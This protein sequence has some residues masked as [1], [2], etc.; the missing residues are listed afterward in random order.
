Q[1]RIA[2]G[3]LVV[4]AGIS[5]RFAGTFENQ[6]RAE[7]RLMVLIP[8]VLTLI[9]LVLYLQFRRSSTA[10]I[11]FTGIAVAWTG[12]FL[13]IGLYAQPWFADFSVAGVNM[14]DLSQVGPV[15]L[16]I[17][18]WVGFIALFGIAVDDGVVMATY[19]DQR[20]KGAT[21]ANRDDPRAAVL[22]AGLRRIRPCL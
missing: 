15:N 10:F 14:R 11:V 16:S 20:F 2:R 3:E 18:V 21:L 19:L 4:P 22:E 1:A 8:L 9:F 13:L 12:G 17:A 7:K 6:V 5:Y